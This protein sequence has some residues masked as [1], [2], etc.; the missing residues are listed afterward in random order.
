MPTAAAIQKRAEREAQHLIKRGLGMD[1][2]AAKAAMAKLGELERAV[3]EGTDLQKQVQELAA[4]LEMANRGKTDAEIRTK[5]VQRRH[6]DDRLQQRMRISAL[7]SGINETHMDFV[8]FE[9]RK[10]V[11]A[12]VK[13]RTPIPK[14]GDFFRGMKK[15]HT[16]LFAEQPPVTATPSTAPPE[17]GTPGTAPG[18]TP[19]TPAATAP[20]TEK[21]AEQMTP[22]E[23]RAHQKAQYGFTPGA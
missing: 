9:Y 16:Y 22:A 19:P 3:S 1:L 12:A 10:A 4:Q 5:N 14:A 23:F 11:Q 21:N 7:Q 6:S 13:A 8:I 17:G 20:P 15:T 18:T 2:D